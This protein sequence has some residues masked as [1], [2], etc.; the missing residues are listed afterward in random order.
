MDPLFTSRIAAKPNRGCDREKCAP[1]FFLFS[2][3]GT[4]N[5]VG[6]PLVLPWSMKSPMVVG[7][8]SWFFSWNQFCH[9][10]WIVG[11]H[12]HLCLK[13]LSK[14]VTGWPFARYRH[15]TRHE[16]G[17]SW[18]LWTFEEPLVALEKSHEKTPLHSSPV[19][20]HKG[21]EANPKPTRSQP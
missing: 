4:E 2:K 7:L 15:H 18:S 3:I 20:V 10:H 5:C 14:R 16:F 1:F 9:H 19:M 21:I 11:W 8:N 17:C 13:S 6:S 12:L